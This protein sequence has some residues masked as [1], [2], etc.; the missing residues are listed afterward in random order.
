[1]SAE[2]KQQ[3][4]DKL[5]DDFDHVREKLRTLIK[6]HDIIGFEMNKLHAEQ[7]ERAA[8]DLETE[9][10][11]AGQ[12]LMSCL[13]V[14]AAKEQDLPDVDVEYAG[15]NAMLV[16]QHLVASLQRATETSKSLQ[17]RNNKL[18]LDILMFFLVTA[19]YMFTR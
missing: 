8:R 14:I 3:L 2:C 16:I 6:F 10:V 11:E 15:E 7:T 17:T 1:M 12:R 5:G 18:Q 4:L 19:I 9:K 13:R